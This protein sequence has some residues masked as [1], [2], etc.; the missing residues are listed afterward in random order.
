MNLPH[1]E[2]YLEI[3]SRG[4]DATSNLPEGWEM[5]RD[6]NGAPEPHACMSAAGRRRLRCSRRSSHPQRRPHAWHDAIYHAWGALTTPT[7]HCVGGPAPLAAACAV[8]MLRRAPPQ[9]AWHDAW[10]GRAASHASHAS[11]T[12][13]DALLGRAPPLAARAYS[14]LRTAH[15]HARRRARLPWQATCTCLLYTSDAADE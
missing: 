9:H 12:S 6:P 8:Y 4:L 2:Q 13:H 11:H 5:S 1:D 15:V 10:H 14:L 3:A 7:L